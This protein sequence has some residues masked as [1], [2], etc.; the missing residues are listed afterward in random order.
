[1]SP[2]SRLL[3]NFAKAQS[4]VGLSGDIEIEQLTTLVPLR[5]ERQSH[6][7]Y[8][9]SAPRPGSARR[10]TLHSPAGKPSPAATLAP[11]GRAE[12]RARNNTASA[13]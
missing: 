8:C 1:M 9:S 5:L 3:S 4:E 13:P 7:R 11:A 6:R 2:P 12:W 10:A